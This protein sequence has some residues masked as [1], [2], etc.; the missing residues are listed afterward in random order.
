M[1][2]ERK[3]PDGARPIARAKVM[4]AEPPHLC[5]V[6]SATRAL[7]RSAGFSESA[8]FQAVIG[9]TDFAY[10]QYLGSDRPVD[11]DLSA[12]RHPDGLELRAEIAGPEAPARVSFPFAL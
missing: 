2:R 1:A 9:V 10:G 5:R 12:L 4:V 11:I 3:S 8:V 7:C 6:Q